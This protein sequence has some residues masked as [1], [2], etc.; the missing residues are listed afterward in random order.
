MNTERP[1]LQKSDDARRLQRFTHIVTIGLILGCNTFLFLGLW[2]SGVDLEA[3]L[4]KPELYDPANGDCVGVQWAKVNG[5]EGLVKICTEWIDFS[6]ISGQ[7][8]SLPPGR[9]LAMGADGNLYFPGQS[10]ENYRLIALMIFAIVVMASGMWV[11]RQLIA[12][13]QS[14]LQSFDHQST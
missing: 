3:V 11:K 2:V 4:A 9:T 12:K 13:Y 10:T 5:A 8:H 7:T 1:V 6:D 14:R